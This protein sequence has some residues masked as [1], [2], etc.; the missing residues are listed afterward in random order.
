[1][2]KLGMKI[3]TL[4]FNATAGYI[5]HMRSNYNQ[6]THLRK[7]TYE[8]TI[9]LIKRKKLG[10]S[11]FWELSDPLFIRN[12]VSFSQAGWSSLLS[13]YFSLLCYY[14]P[15]EKG[16]DLLLNKLESLVTQGIFCAKFGWNWS[17]GSGEEVVFFYNFINVFSLFSCHFPFKEEAVLLLKKLEFPLPRILCAKFDWEWLCGSG[18]EVENGNSF[19]TTNR[20]TDGRTHR[21]S[22][23]AHLIFQ[24]R[25][26]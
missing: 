26:A 11:S 17:S 6:L 5:A 20:Q 24:L 23:K 25:W 16:V 18:E 8:Y 7:A 10:W 2:W 9:T 19:Q 12:W 15:L 22:E 1:M 21:P 14:L 3:A 13:M 4:S